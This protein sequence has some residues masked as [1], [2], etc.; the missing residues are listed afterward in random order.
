MHRLFAD[1]SMAE[2]ELVIVSLA[3]ENI[4]NSGL[5]SGKT[6]CSVTSHATLVFGGRTRIVHDS[7][8]RTEL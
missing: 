5:T 3:S 1:V 4:S 2:I 7:N 8:L 6:F